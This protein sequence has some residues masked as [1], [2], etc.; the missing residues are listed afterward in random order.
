T[1]KSKKSGKLFIDRCGQEML[2]RTSVVINDKDIEARI[3]VGLPAAGRKILGKAAAHT[4]IDI[5]PE[6]VNHALR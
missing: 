5:L 3:E 6:I 2:E 4:L 1:Q